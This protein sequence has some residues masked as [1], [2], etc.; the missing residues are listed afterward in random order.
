MVE[1]IEQSET[2]IPYWAKEEKLTEDDLLNDDTF[3][4]DAQQT[5]YQRTGQTYIE[6]KEILDAYLEQFR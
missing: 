3:L 1:Q 6:P 4:G 2:A 5:L